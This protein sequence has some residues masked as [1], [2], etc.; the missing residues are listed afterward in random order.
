MANQ[1]NKNKKAAIEKKKRQKKEKDDNKNRHAARQSERKSSRNQTMDA[2][3]DDSVPQTI[4]N[5]LDTTDR[6]ALR[7]ASPKSEDEVEAEMNREQ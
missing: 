5:D 2:K 4:K 7:A 3:A 6:Q 1:R